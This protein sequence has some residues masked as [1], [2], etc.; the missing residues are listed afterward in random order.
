M[1]QLVSASLNQKISAG[2]VKK[3][4]DVPVRVGTPLLTGTLRFTRPT[5]YQAIWNN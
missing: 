4:S 1:E 3:R 2:L 5:D